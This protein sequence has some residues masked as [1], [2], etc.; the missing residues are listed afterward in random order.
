VQRA[1]IRNLPPQPVEIPRTALAPGYL[2]LGLASAVAWLLARDWVAAAALWV[3][4]AG[5]RNLG[6]SVGPPV[7]AAAFTFQW[8]QVS[9]GLYYFALTGVRLPALDLSEYQ[10]MVLIGLGCLVALLVG[11][12]LGMKFV[13]PPARSA[14]G[15]PAAFGWRPLIVTYLVSIAVTGT[16]QEFAWGVPVLTQGILALTYARFALLFLMFR[17]L[18]RPRVRL[19]WIALLLAGE[20]TLGFTGY[21]AGFREPMMMAAVALADAFDRR[22][23]RNWVMLGLLGCVMLF[24][25]AL[26]MGIRGEYRRDLE[27]E[28]FSGSR[29]AR[30]EQV[31][32]L[33]S[34]WAQR[35]PAEMI[36]DVE[37]LVERL[38]AVYYPALAVTRVPALVPHENGAILWTAV[39]HALT[40][41]FL[42]PDKPGLESDSE[43]VRRF[44]GVWV[45]GPEE[46]TSI[47]F[48]YAAESYVDFGVPLMFLPVLAYGLLMGMAYHGLLRLI[49]SEELGVALV[50]VVLWLS[51]YPFERSWANMLGLS[52]TLIAY[53]GGA[54][55]LLDRLL[56]MRRGLRSPRPPALTP[57]AT[58]LSWRMD[59]GER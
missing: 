34:A 43:K 45:H 38:W 25:G 55:L 36:A 28:V 39:V 2:L 5:W 56:L 24:T 58:R 54:T 37:F 18:T 41:R 8:I 32:A 16:V 46:N 4:W 12:K 52:L 47:A 51:L 21:F 59:G 49:R 7:L 23:W 3:L 30:L 6:T 20:T 33:S 40:P 19:G 14:G 42:F 53:L 27:S 11:L 10:P 22:K 35:S 9:I 44:S 1:R 26:W 48:G 13:R 17:H 50:T 29:E 57:R 31:A 15:E